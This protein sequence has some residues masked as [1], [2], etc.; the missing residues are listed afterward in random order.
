MITLLA[1][2]IFAIL[3]AFTLTP[4]TRQALAIITCVLVLLLWLIFV[5]AISV[6]GGHWLA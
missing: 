3:A 1:L 6:H 5:G 2:T 4:A